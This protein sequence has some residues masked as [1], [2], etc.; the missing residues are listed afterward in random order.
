RDLRGK[1]SV[2]STLEDIPGIGPARRTALLQYFK[3]VKAIKEADLEELQKVSGMNAKAA[4]AVYDWAHP[5]QEN[6]I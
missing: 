3:S 6:G 2:H 5:A 1:A 4:K